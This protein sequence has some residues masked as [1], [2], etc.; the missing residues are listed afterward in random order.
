MLEASGT[1]AKG[2]AAAT[3]ATS[4]AGFAA[5]ALVGLGNPEAAASPASLAVAPDQIPNPAPTS[6]WLRPVPPGSANVHPSV[7]VAASP[8]FLRASEARIGASRPTKVG[9]SPFVGL[10][11]A[12]RLRKFR[13][14]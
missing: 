5:W 11:A 2:E 14:T 8:L 3:T 9:G 12:I 4:V 1:V 10:V 13:R 7:E 6:V